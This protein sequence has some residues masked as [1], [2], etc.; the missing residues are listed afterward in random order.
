MTSLEI[1]SCKF[2]YFDSCESLCIEKLNVPSD[3]II[4]IWLAKVKFFLK[5]IP[6]TFNFV[7]SDKVMGTYL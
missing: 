7:E 3:N 2:E 1:V 4:Q 5:I 6:N